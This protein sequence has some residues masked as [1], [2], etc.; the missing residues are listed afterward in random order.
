M[1]SVTVGYSDIVDGLKSKLDSNYAKVEELTS[2]LMLVI[3]VIIFNV[4]SH[5]GGNFISS[6]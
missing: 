1:I 4:L 3:I 6:C 5:K 2:R